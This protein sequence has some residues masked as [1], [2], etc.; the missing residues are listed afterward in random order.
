MPQRMCSR[1]SAAHQPSSAL[2]MICTPSS[3]SSMNCSGGSSPATSSTFRRQQMAGQ[4]L[5]WMAGS[6]TAAL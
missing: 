5:Q 2:P 1:S 6:G 3:S 4:R